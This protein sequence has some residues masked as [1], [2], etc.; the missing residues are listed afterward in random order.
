[1]IL[2]NKYFLTFIKKYVWIDEKH[3]CHEYLKKYDGITF[4]VNK[5]KT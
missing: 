1:M 4:S 2:F 5:L 3:I